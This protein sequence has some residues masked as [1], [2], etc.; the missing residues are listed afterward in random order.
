MIHV[1]FPDGSQREYAPGTTGAEIAAQISKSL[2]KKAV[3]M[4]L[5]GVLSDLNDPIITDAKL[6]IVT[7]DNGK[8]LGMRDPRDTVRFGLMGM[9]ERTEALGGSFSVESEA[10]RGV[11]VRVSIPLVDGAV[12][13]G[14]E[15]PAAQAAPQSLS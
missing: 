5:D 14:A 13:N 2:A 8:G 9:R 1:T 4:S 6:E 10:G 3:A 7:R 11:T 12:R 15:S